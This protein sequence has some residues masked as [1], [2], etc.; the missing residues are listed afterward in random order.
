M[1]GSAFKVLSK[2]PTHALYISEAG[3]L[4]DLR[5]G[6]IR[7]TQQ[8]YSLPKPDGHDLLMHG[9]VEVFPEAALQDT[10]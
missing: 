10:P 8:F 1:F 5:D 7:T 9:T 2:C 3:L 6:K 4:R